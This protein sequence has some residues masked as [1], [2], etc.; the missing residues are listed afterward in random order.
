MR[1]GVPLLSSSGAKIS[2]VKGRGGAWWGRRGRGCRAGAKAGIGVGSL[3]LRGGPSFLSPVISE[4][5]FLGC[6]RSG[7]A[8]PR[9]HPGLDT[10]KASGF[11]GDAS[12]DGMWNYQLAP[13]VGSRA[14]CVRGAGCVTWTGGLWLSS[15]VLV[16]S[17][18]REKKRRTDG[19]GGKQEN[20]A[21]LGM[22]E[23]K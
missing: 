8:C 6:P 3:R 1:L 20:E 19:G 10:E 21:E 18:G 22:K 7:C 15:S 13:L 17:F 16:F 5:P 14:L 23:E 2:K 11:V 12:E 9:V 4:L